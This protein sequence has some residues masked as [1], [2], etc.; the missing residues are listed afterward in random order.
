M[1]GGRLYA[2][3]L[4]GECLVLAASPRFELLAQNTVRERVLSSPAI[5]D[6]A[7]LMRSYQ[8]LWCIGQ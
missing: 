2:T 6:G 8:H 3:N 4:A 7:L 5:S 1:A